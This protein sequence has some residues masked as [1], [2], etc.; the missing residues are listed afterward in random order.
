MS[1]PLHAERSAAPPQA[2]EVLRAERLTKSYA[3]IRALRDGS[4]TLRAGEVHALIGENGAGKSTLTKIIT[5]AVAADGGELTLFGNA[6][7]EN[8]PNLSRS[9]GIA[10]IYQQPSLFP[11]LSVAEN[12]AL[13][14]EQGGASWLV[15]WKARAVRARELLLSVGSSIDPARAARTLSMAEQQIVEI[16]KAIGA[17]ARILLMDEPTALLS[18]REVRNLFLLIA[19]LRTDGVAVVYI[20]HRLEEVLAI[21]DRITVLRDGETVA[22]R[23]AA[24]VNK[25]ELIQLMVGRPIESI[26]PKRTVSMGAVAL[27]VRDLTHAESG[28]HKISFAVRRGEILGFAGLVGSG[29]TELARVLFGLTPAD[30]N[31]F[32]HGRP[33]RLR[34]PADAIRNG[35]AYLPEDRRQHGV[36]LDMSIAENISM[37]DLSAV[38]SMGLIDHAKEVNLANEYRSR[39]RIK[40]PTVAVA[41]GTL[42]GGNQQKVALARWLATKPGIIILDEP[43]QGVDVGS[44]SEIHELIV[45]LAEQG[46]AVILISSELP[47]VLGMSDRI[48]VFHAGTIRGVLPREQAT[49]E[50]I[51]ALAFGH[52]EANA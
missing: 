39:L 35:I 46:M 33:V 12:I 8:S 43:T 14:L 21:A 48:A 51:L 42:S 45:E 37:A 7:Q 32:V 52:A 50:N 28:L 10:A 16:A 44:K 4:L 11:D 41:A 19:A 27:E 26:Y 9:L 36:V 18:D 25:A 38:S 1:D 49:Q 20:S 13:A 23:S 30:A 3:G 31:V 47:E 40:A 2:A 17:N 5:G 22:V 34:S 29:R 6:V 24:E 15:D